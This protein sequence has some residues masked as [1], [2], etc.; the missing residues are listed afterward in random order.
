MLSP[1]PNFI[2]LLVVLH[3]LHNEIAMGCFWA[4]CELLQADAKHGRTC[5]SGD[6]DAQDDLVLLKQ[7]SEDQASTHRLQDI[8][9]VQYLPVLPLKP[10][11]M[12]HKALAEDAWGPSCL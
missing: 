8:L 3:N 4:E 5:S 2:M 11:R 6:A 1:F 10:L 12:P 9:H 7:D